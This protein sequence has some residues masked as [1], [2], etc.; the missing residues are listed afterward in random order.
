M[1]FMDIAPALICDRCKG[2]LQIAYR[3]KKMALGKLSY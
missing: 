1:E 2:N 3:L